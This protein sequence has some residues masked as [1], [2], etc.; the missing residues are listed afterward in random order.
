MTA[1]QCDRWDEFE[2]AAQEELHAQWQAREQKLWEDE[3]RSAQ[4]QLAGTRLAFRRFNDDSFAACPWHSPRVAFIAIAPDAPV[5]FACNVGQ[6]QDLLRS[7]YVILVAWPGEWS[8]HV[9]L[10]S[11]QDK[12]SVLAALGS[13]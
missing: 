5:T 8:Q 7:G 1:E 6:K 4:E 9:F 12:A 10:L 11:D 3:K 13:Q 2:R